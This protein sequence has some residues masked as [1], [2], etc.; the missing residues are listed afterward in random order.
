MLPEKFS[1]FLEAPVPFVVGV[2]SLPENLPPND[3]VIYDVAKKTI[4]T[5][6]KIPKLPRFN[7]LYPFSLS[8]SLFRS[9][10]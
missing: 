4:N 9:F 1:N 6:E 10:F 3:L 2:V 7:E 8:F 5:Q